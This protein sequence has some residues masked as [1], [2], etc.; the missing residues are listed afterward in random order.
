MFYDF[1]KR[2]PATVKIILE[3]K[4]QLKKKFEKLLYKAIEDITQN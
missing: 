1:C 3:L 4:I 2:F